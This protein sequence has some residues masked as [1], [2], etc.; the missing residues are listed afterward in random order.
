MEL[1]WAELVPEFSGFGLVI[2]TVVFVVTVV[3]GMRFDPCDVEEE[4]GIEIMNH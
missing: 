2:G 1:L 4:G 3:T